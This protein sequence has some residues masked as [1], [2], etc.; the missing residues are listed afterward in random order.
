MQGLPNVDNK[1]GAPD[2]VAAA[3]WASE[4]GVR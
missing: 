2:R 1:T 3:N 4:H